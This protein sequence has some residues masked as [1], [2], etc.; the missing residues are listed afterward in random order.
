M[1]HVLNVLCQLVH[2]NKYAGV[3]LR[4]LMIKPQETKH[5]LR[6]KAEM[7]FEQEIRR[8]PNETPGRLLL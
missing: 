3:M 6:L 8:Q 5:R 2:V 7:M 1:L 4:P